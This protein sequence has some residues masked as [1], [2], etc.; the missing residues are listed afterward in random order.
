MKLPLVFVTACLAGGV[1]GAAGSMIGHAAGTGG[2]IVGGI[3]GGTLLVVAAGFL[4]ARMTWIPAVRRLWTVLGGVFGFF[5]ACLVALSTLS[6]PIG[7][8]LSTLLIGTGAV[9]GATVGQ[10]A[11]E[12]GLTPGRRA[13]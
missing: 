10:S 9:L 12:E 13:R 2:V 4:A 8:I 3:L 5:L 1:G 6:S 11:H 7:P